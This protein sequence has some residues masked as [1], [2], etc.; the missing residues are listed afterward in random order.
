MHGAIWQMRVRK[1]AVSQQD[2]K[3]ATAPSLNACI[4]LEQQQRTSYGRGSSNRKPNLNEGVQ[5][6]ASTIHPVLLCGGS[7]AR[8][9]PISRKSYPKQFAKLIGE[10][11]LFQASARR[12]SGH[13]FAAP[14]VVTG[15]DFRFIVTEQ[16]AAVEQVPMAVL[17]EPE[18]RNTAPAILAA[19]LWHLERG[20]DTLLL[21]APSDHVIPDARAFRAAAATAAPL[22]EAGELVTFGI[23]PTRA[24]T[25]YGYLELTSPPGPLPQPLKGFVEKPDFDH[26]RQMVAAG[27]HLWNSGIFLFTAATI[28]D[29][30]RSY[31]PKMVA[32][33]RA[34]LEGAETDLGFTRLLAYP[35][36]VVED[37][38]VDYAI[39]QNA[40]NLAVMPFGADWSDLGD[41]NTIWQESGP[42]ALGNVCSKRATAIDCND[43][44]LRSETPGLELVGIGLEGIIAVAMKDA[45][46]VARKSDAQRVNNVVSILNERGVRQAV[47]LPREYRPWGWYESLVLSDQFQVKRIVV[48]PD[49]KLSLQSHEHRSEHWVVVEGTARVRIDDDVRLVSENQSVH[50]PVGTRHRLENPGKVPTVVIEVQVGSYFGE[51]DITRYED[52]YL[53]N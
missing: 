40:G 7:G 39:M 50:V 9:W 11:S 8:L 36:A 45:V 27:Q 16:L 23:T 17:I 10:E 14:T 44:L 2:L 47:Q 42:D 1:A 20:Q 22:A 43:T 12:L 37:I 46:L 51:D 49:A 4:L 38:S 5:A 29:A 48:Y 41:W 18:A 6:L 13:G 31:A 15:E 30:Y 34:S 35:W 33:V 53:R 28:V 3:L 25:G 21:V 26:A 52:A 24:E 19:A 32:A